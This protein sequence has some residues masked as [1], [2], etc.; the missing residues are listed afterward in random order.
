MRQT[1]A[2]GGLPQLRIAV[3]SPLLPGALVGRAQLRGAQQ[4]NRPV[5]GGGA[6]LEALLPCVLVQEQHVFAGE[7]DTHLHTEDTTSGASQVARLSSRTA[8][9]AQREPPG[10]TRRIPLEAMTPVVELLD[11]D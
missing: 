7:A 8:R 10:L 2:D 5:Q 11:S 3:G 9:S 6:G 4:A 1:I